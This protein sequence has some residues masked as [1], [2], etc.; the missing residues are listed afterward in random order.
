MNGVY[1]VYLVIA[2][3]TC[4]FSGFAAT[5]AFLSWRGRN[6]SVPNFSVYFP[7]EKSSRIATHNKITKVVIE[8]KNIGREVAENVET[9]ILFPPEFEIFGAHILFPSGSDSKIL[10]FK[11]DEGNWLSK[12]KYDSEFPNYLNAAFL[13]GNLGPKYY[14]SIE[15]SVKTPGT[16]RGY[17]IFVDIICK[18]IGT[19]TYR[20]LLN[21]I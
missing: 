19:K 6:I 8:M 20:L 2:V 5:F 14:N 4:L 17:E 21:V 13:I 10:D 18:G 1:T 11:P 16:P 12:E 3:I 15:I 9:H 7:G